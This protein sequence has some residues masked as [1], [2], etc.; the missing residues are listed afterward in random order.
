MKMND[1]FGWKD[2]PENINS[3]YVQLEG[4]TLKDKEQFGADG[5]RNLK[6]IWCRCQEN[7]NCENER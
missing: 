1:N 2:K 5:R 6:T 4:E 7:P 3:Q